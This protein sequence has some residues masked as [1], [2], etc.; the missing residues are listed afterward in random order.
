MRKKVKKALAVMMMV[1][2]SA[3]AAAIPAVTFVTP[4]MADYYVPATGNYVVTT[5]SVS[6][7]NSGS[8]K[9]FEMPKTGQYPYHYS[10][11]IEIVDQNNWS[12]KY[13]SAYSGQNT[14]R[15]RRS[16]FSWGH[17]YKVHV[18]R[19]VKFKGKLY[20]SGW[21]GYKYFSR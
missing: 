14:I 18:Y 21:S 10:Y 13:Y 12:T 6:V 15:V 19:T 11:T 3:T 4:V 2:A 20:Y 7:Y 17:S 1:L 5:P 9:V 8:Y 16:S